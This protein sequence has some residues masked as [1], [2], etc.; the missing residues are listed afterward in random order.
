MLAIS[1]L[2]FA[3]SERFNITIDTLNLAP[4]FY[5]L[6]GANGAGK[7]SLLNCL[8]GLCEL[9]KGS[10]VL[11]TDA[12]LLVSPAVLALL[13]AKRSYLVQRQ[14][15]HFSI[16]A[17]EMIAIALNLSSSQV[18]QLISNHAVIAGL[19]LAPLCNTPLARLSGGEQQRVHLARV[20][21]QSEH[22][23][24]QLLLLDEPYN[25]L[26]IKHTIWLNQYLMKLASQQI[27]IVSHHELNFAL[28]GEQQV[29]ILK[30]G[31]L[32]GLF[33]SGSEI[34]KHHLMSAFELEADVI[35][36]ENKLYLQ[37]SWQ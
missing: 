23:S 8:A 21:L 34:K 15:T 12:P 35:T 10:I 31:S 18:A 33:A 7:S 22:T 28:K 9:E 13:K 3:L 26:D 29:I 25:G 6:L 36:D 11:G 14:D 24:H 20:L 17:S 37:I 30:E 4:G 5:H 32:Y 16:T 27:V 19:D 1:Q 2:H